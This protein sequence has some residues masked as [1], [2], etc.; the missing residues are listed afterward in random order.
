[1]GASTN[2]EGHERYLDGVLQDFEAMR[3]IIAGASEQSE[4]LLVMLT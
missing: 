2:S 3:I 1:M 4:G